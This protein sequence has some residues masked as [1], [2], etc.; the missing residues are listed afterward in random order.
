MTPTVDMGL[1][2]TEITAP[3][4]K[5]ITRE[6]VKDWLRIDHVEEDGEIDDLITMATEDVE[7]Y[8]GRAL[9]TQT[10]DLYLDYFPRDNRPVK[11]PKPPLQSIT[12][13]TYTDSNGTSGTT[14]ASTKYVVDTVSE[15]GRI[16][17]K[18]GETWPSTYDEINA[19]T[20]RFVCGYGTTQDTVPAKIKQRMKILISELYTHRE[21]YMVGRLSIKLDV[22]EKLFIDTRV[23]QF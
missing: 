15:I 10:H 21:I 19:V 18:S 11:V 9:I 20:I 6:E 7:A 2:T 22:F 3:T 5:P 4:K 23:W 8:T 1:R 13:I 14:F 16:G 12:S 17:L